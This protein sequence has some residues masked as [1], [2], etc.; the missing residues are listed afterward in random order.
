[1]L[2]LKGL[3]GRFERERFRE[4]FEMR[5]MV[6]FNSSIVRMALWFVYI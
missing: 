2:G 4:L 3:S 6:L 5:K 1:M